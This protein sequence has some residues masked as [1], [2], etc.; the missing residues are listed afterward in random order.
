MKNFINEN[1]SIIELT[2]ADAIVAGQPIVSGEMHFIPLETNAS[3]VS[4][5]VSTRIEGLFWLPKEV[6]ASGK[7]VARGVLLYWDN[8][9]NRVTTT[10]GSLKKLGHCVTPAASTD[11][12][13]AVSV[14]PL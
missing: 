3:T 6:A 4:K 11:E 2:T 7:G 12:E 9:N 1:H 10:A 13:V 14:R 8:T 5:S